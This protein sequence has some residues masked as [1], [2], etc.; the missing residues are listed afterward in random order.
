MVRHL[1]V[2]DD[3]HEW[4]EFFVA[5]R[6]PEPRTSGG[7]RYTA[8][9]TCYSSFGVFGHHWYDMG[10]PFAE[11][12]RG[13]DAGYLIGKIG[14]RVFSEEKAVRAVRNEIVGA[15]VRKA[16]TK[17][18]AR[19]AFDAV[20]QIEQNYSGEAVATMLYEDADIGHVH[21]EWSELESMEWDRSTVL[22]A[23]KIWPRFVEA[24]QAEAAVGAA[25]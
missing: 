14:R 16:I 8:T 23:E 5:E 4:G 6:D 13:M 18:A 24:I 21:I 19:D 17:E 3:R 2:R 9:W 25:P 22:F 10:A 12:I 20:E 15:R 11:F 1:I 7:L